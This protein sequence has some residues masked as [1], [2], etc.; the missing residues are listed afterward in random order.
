MQILNKYVTSNL[1]SKQIYWFISVTYYWKNAQIRIL[2]L[3]L[4]KVLVHFVLNKKK[5]E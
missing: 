3:E 1:K 5:K 2:Y 4:K